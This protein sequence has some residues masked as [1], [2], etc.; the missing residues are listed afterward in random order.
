MPLK[1]YDDPDETP[2]DQSIESVKYIE[3]VTG[4]TFNVHVSVL[5]GYDFGRCDGLKV[6]LSFDG[7]DRIWLGFISKSDTLQNQANGIYRFQNFT[8][9]DP[10]TQQWRNSNLCFA[11]VKLKEGHGA[12]QASLKSL[13]KLGT[14]KVRVVRVHRKKRAPCEGRRDGFTEVSEVSEKLLKGKAITNS[15]KYSVAP[16]ALEADVD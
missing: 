2:Q 4:A 3:S 7:G 14:I 6:Q 16:H 10:A 12:E 13:S 5:G 1:E 15:V 8:V 9:F 11:E